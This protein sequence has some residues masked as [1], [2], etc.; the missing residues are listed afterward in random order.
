MPIRRTDSRINT[1]DG[2][3]IVTENNNN[4]V[5]ESWV[6]AGGGHGISRGTRLGNPSSRDIARDTS[7]LWEVGAS[8]SSINNTSLRERINVR[9]FLI[10]ENDINVSNASIYSI[11]D[12]AYKEKVNIRKYISEGNNIKVTISE[13]IIL[14]KPKIINENVTVTLLSTRIKE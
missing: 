9:K 13:D 11:N 5:L 2:F 12:T 8:I 1:E 14:R 6:A 3:S 10:E 4:L 7:E